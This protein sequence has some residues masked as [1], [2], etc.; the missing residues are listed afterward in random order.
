MKIREYLNEKWE[1]AKGINPDKKGMWDGW[2]ISK[3]KKER[4]RL[5]AIEDRSEEESTRL[6]EVNF[7]LRAKTGWGAVPK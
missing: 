6:R 1:G 3:L 7:A 4:E 5:L 2:S